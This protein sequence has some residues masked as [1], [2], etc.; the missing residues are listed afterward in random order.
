GLP[1][2]ERHGLVSSPVRPPGRVHPVCRSNV[3]RL[4]PPVARRGVGDTARRRR[5]RPSDARDRFDLSEW[6]VL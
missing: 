4:E 2:E 5:H 3:S 1:P 6:R